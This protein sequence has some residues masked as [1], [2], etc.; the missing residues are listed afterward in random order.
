MTDKLTTV[1]I[2]IGNSDDKLSQSQ[3]AHFCSAVKQ[4][5]EAHAFRVH[6]CGGSEADAPWQ[7]MC[8]VIEIQP[9]NTNSLKDVL[10]NVANSYGQESIAWT[11]GETIMLQG[12]V[13][14]ATAFAEE[15]A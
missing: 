4:Q 14:P 12:K 2:Q 15:K 9:M 8:W 10:R 7:N 6:F 3:W 5:I 11:S 1:T 13:N